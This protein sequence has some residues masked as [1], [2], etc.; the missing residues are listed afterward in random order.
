[1]S[2]LQRA[3]MPIL[4]LLSA[5][6]AMGGELDSR[7][8][9]M[10]MFVGEDIE[11]LSIAS[12]REESAWAA[13]AIAR[14]LTRRE[15]RERGIDTL[16]QAL[17]TL[18]GFHMARREWG[19][20]PYL[21]GVPNSI[22]FL[23]DAV[24]VMSDVRKSLHPLDRELSLAPV[25]RIEII[26]GPGS[27]LWGPDAFGGIVNIVPLTGR[28]LDG[29]ETGALFGA[30]GDDHRAFLNYGF[31]HGSWDAFFS[32]TGRRVR[33]NDDVVDVL[34]FFGDKSEPVPPEDRFGRATPGDARYVDGMVRIARDDWL[35][36]TARI[37]ESR[38][39]Y[40]MHYDPA[41]LS[42]REEQRTPTGF[43]KLEARKDLGVDG[44][45]RFMGSRNWL[46]SETE[47]IDRTL[48]H[49][50]D[51]SYAEILYDRSLFLGD[52]LFT[53]GVSWRHKRIRNAPVWDG[54]LPEF[55]KPEN[56]LL[57]PVITEESY[58]T[59]LWSFFTQYRHKIGSNLDLWGGLRFDHHDSYR[60]HVSYNLGGAWSPFPAWMVKL[61]YGNAY[62]TPFARQL[63]GEGDPDMEEIQSLNLQVAW[64]PDP[65]MELSLTGFASRINHHILEDP[66]AGLSEPNRQDI[67]GLEVEARL[68]PHSSLSLEAGL[69]LLDNSGPNETYRYNDF[70][71][72]RPD[73]TV[74][75][76]FVDL[77]YPYDLGADILFNLTAL[78]RPLDQWTLHGRASWFS[79]RDQVALSEGEFVTIPAS[80]DWRLDAG[81]LVED[82]FASGL[83]FSG[84]IRNLTD[85]RTETPGTYGLIEG[86]GIDGLFM[87][88][89]R[90]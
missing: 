73:G 82:I 84:T 76:N 63:L 27:V 6:S 78:W 47:V 31:A 2:N 87:L 15:L 35:T 88:R 90:W 49:R 48:R 62:R 70:T 11:V 72:I 17:D 22:L 23:Y 44:A 68:R 7:E 45:V 85:R 10:L 67:Q 8:A 79:S 5:V 58:E 75:R 33:E 41:G 38:R 60:D 50:E 19:T 4:L 1:M 28:D 12:R 64:E 77:D 86:E 9:T 40:A 36:L 21:R 61:L 30:P 39:P 32:L 80:S 37:A 71:F 20:L 65:R 55:L 29:F 59:R 13:P 42:W 25:K 57:L 16:G 24:P 53:G 14:V 34:R 26:R 18:P 43:L 74:E 83:D 3:L 54:Y 46:V 52:A 81:F 89:W 56:E 69:T 66:Y 51:T